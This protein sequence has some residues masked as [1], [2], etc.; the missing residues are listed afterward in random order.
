VGETAV[1]STSGGSG[2]GK[3]TYKATATGA[4]VCAITGNQLLAT[5]GAGACEVKATKAAST[6]YLSTTATLSVPVGAP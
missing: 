5:G 3:V 1:L 2:P 6:N 4:T